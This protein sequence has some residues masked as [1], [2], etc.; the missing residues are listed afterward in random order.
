MKKIDI[1]K[2][3]NIATRAIE[4]NGAKMTLLRDGVQIASFKGILIDNV[5]TDAGSSPS[6]TTSTSR[7][8]LMPV[9]KQT[10]QVGDTISYNS[11]ILTI[12]TLINVNPTG[13]SVIYKVNVL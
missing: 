1:S 12:T 10:P 9:I 13:T 8:V 11:E 3:K 2:I 4:T 7:Q 5:K 6:T